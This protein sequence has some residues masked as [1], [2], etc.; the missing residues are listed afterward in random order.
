LLEGNI[1][2]N[3]IDFVAINHNFFSNLF[4][5]F[6]YVATNKLYLSFYFEKFKSLN[7]KKNILDI[8]V[9]NF[10]NLKKSCKLIGI[11]HHYSHLASAFYDSPFTESVNL[12]IDAFGDFSS[13][14]W[15]I[16]NHKKIK[17]DDRVL[18]PHSLG[19]F[20]EAFTQF[21]GF[22]N[23][24]DEYKIMGLSS[25][26]KVADLDLDKM[27]KIIKIEKNGKFSLNL[28]YFNHHKD[29]ISYS[30]DNC[31]PKTN[32]LFNKNFQNLFFNARSE[33]ENLK[34]CHKNLA[35]AVQYKYEEI[36]FHVLNYIYDKYKMLEEMSDK[37][38]EY[39]KLKHWI[40]QVLNIPFNN[41]VQ[42]HINNTTEFLKHIKIKLDTD[43]FGMKNVKEELMLQ[44]INRFIK[45]RK[46]ELILSLVGSA[47]VGKTKIIHIMAQSLN[48][49][50]YHISLGGIKDGSFLDG[51]S[52]T[53]VGSKQG[54]IVDALIKMN[55]NNG[56]IFFEYFKKIF[57]MICLKYKIKF[58]KNKAIEYL[59]ECVE[60]DL[61]N[62]I[63]LSKNI[64]A[65]KIGCCIK[66]FT[67]Q[68][69]HHVHVFICCPCR[70][71]L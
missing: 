61:Q 47:G 27:K 43:L 44:I 24:G 56:I 42:L 7:K 49:P 70:T 14:S 66:V 3:D 60:K 34:D 39:F 23:F 13:V 48:L 53:Y 67:E 41:S 8:L 68:S 69:K 18:F 25:Y 22:C 33:N 12:S 21:L 15:G 63:T 16:G 38:T 62:K 6:K 29:R 57:T 20:Y 35:S 19:I 17:I 71:V 64:V 50:F 45:K 1:S 36:L 37:D 52:N 51:F 58:V 9:K 31:S 4:N 2:I 65:K 32:L 30:W 11:D 46:S 28:N 10:G 54:I 5:K 26:G 59:I 55:C 40:L